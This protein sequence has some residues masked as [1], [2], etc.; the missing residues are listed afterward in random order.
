MRGVVCYIGFDTWVLTQI[1]SVT[2]FTAQCIN[3]T[4]TGN[5]QHL[6]ERTWRTPYPAHFPKFLRLH[7]KLTFSRI[8]IGNRA[9]TAGETGF[10][11][12]YTQITT[13]LVSR[14]NSEKKV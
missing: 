3:A 6:R 8:G 10:A 12:I 1:L 4:K 2:A 13:K 11:W 14:E 7:T 5:D 9:S